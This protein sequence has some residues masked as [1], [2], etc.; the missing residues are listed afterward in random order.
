MAGEY[1]TIIVGAGPAGLSAAIYACRRKMKTVVIA[2]E[3]G[4]QTN[5]AGSIEN[6]PGA[7]PM[8]GMQLMQQFFKQAK[9]FGAVFLR[10]S[11][12]KI[13]RAG[14]LFTVE[15][16]DKEKV[17]GK[18]VILAYGKTPRKL[19]APG[20]EK[21]IGKGISTCATCDGV[22]FK[23]K[24]VAIV[25]GG[26]AALDAALFL[27]KIAKSVHLIHRRADFRGDEVMVEK[28]KKEARNVNFI[29]ESMVTEFKG[30]KF[31]KSIKIA[32]AKGKTTE[33]AVDGVFMEIG[34]VVDSE[35]VKG[36]VKVNEANEIEVDG[37][38]R[39]SQE[40]IFAAGDVTNVP[41]KQAVVAA[42]EGAKAALEAY[43]YVYGHKYGTAS[44]DW[45]HTSQQGKS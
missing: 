1:D 39:T 33:L 43:N 16:G 3:V 35:W 7:E 13:K 41:Y 27:S 37:H 17:T 19:G 28:I 40:G 45:M 38:N 5:L 18:T 4:G 21:F 26:N 34:Y 20:E 2:E 11:A 9:G 31:L 44:I 25:G 22:L 23:G 15:L 6:Y 8:P 36:T 14:K 12:A 10:G 29:L 30:D 24:V 42:G 32:D